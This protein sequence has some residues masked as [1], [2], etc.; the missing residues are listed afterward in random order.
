[1]RSPIQG[2]RSVKLQSSVTKFIDATL[3]LN[4]NSRDGYRLLLIRFPL[5]M[6]FQLT[7]SLRMEGTGVCDTVVRI[8]ILSQSSTTMNTAIV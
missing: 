6:T 1:M 7:L 3:L 5:S 8:T 2:R 4:G